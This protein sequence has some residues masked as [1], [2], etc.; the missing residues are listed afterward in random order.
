VRP[1]GAHRA[2][3]TAGPAPRRRL[4][5][6]PATLTPAVDVWR[7]E[8]GD[9]ERDQRRAAAAL[10]RAGLKPG[11]RVALALPNSPALL[12]IV[13]GAARTG[14][15]PVLLN[16]GLLPAEIA[17]L[18]EDAQAQLTVEDPAAFI[19]TDDEAELAPFPLCRPMHYT[20]GTSGRPKGV[21]SGIW[22]DDQARRAH[23]DEADIW[24][25]GPEDTHLTCSPLYHSVA[26]RFSAQALLRGATLVLLSRF[27]APTAARTLHQETIR[28]AFMVPTHLQRLAAEP[29]PDLGDLRLL[30]HAG[31]ACPEPL[32]R[33]WLDRVPN[34]WEFY[35]STEGQFTVCPPGD[36]LDHPGTVGRARPGRR[37]TADPDGQIWCEVQDFGRFEYWRDPVKTGTAWRGEAFTVG[38]LGRLD[39]D[40]FLYLDGRRDD[41]IISG[42]VNVYPAEVEQAL[43]E[44]PGVEEIAVFGVPDDQ[45]GQRVC[46]AVVGTADPEAVL[47]HAQSTLAPHKRPKQVFLVDDLPRTGTG[48]V[49]RAHVATHL[50]LDN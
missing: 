34:I 30:A 45:W 46:A 12:A 4:T 27:D 7:I 23:E 13:L 39:S 38:D 18:V 41:L 10:A 6:E 22:S 5:A 2:G 36:W 15:V 50:G 25:L 31:A 37:L 40:G 29:L 19:D 3:R 48:K 14:V 33:A 16:A 17:A 26:I 35:G 32:K 11:D 47:A 21:W 9:A 20:S 8:P 49:R 24:G 44:V 42:G 43:H 28:S 1:D